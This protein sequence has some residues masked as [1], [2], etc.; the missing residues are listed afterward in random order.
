[1]P[2]DGRGSV[3][4]AGAVVVHLLLTL[5]HGVTHVTVPVA[6]PGWQLL[7]AIA[8]LFV[9]PVA[10]AVLSL[11]GRPWVGSWLLVL[12]GLGGLLL[13]G[14]LHFLV[15]NPDNVATV[16]HAGF[17]A[18]AVLT[19]GSDALLVVVAGLVLLARAR[20]GVAS[21]SPIDFS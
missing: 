8:V 13:E 14:T 19:T 7:T 15:V 5:A 2:A 10:G 9:V 3:A 20:A 4:V 17:T 18:T 6:I 16:D 11:R 1:M 12:A 21:H